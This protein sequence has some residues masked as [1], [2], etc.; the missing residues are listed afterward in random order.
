[1]LARQMSRFGIKTVILSPGLK[2]TSV[3]LEEMYELIRKIIMHYNNYNINVAIHPHFKQCIFYKSEII[4]LL[5]NIKPSPWLLVDTVH[6][7]LAKIDIIY[8]LNDYREYIVGIHLKDYIIKDSRIEICSLGNGVVDI[9][10]ILKVVKRI[11]I[12]WII[13]EG[14]DKDTQ[15]QQTLKD[16][17]IYL[18]NINSIWSEECGE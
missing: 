8:F 6:F 3:D 4:S 10:K 16:S 13:I 17:L 1:M 11:G 7:A 2:F 14:K 15:P 18:N 5:S 9:P 12:K